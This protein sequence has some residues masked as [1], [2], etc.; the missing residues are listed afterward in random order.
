V[1]IQDGS[2]ILKGKGFGHGVGMC[3]WGARQLAQEGKSPE[4][5]IR[6]YFKGV[7]I[8]KYWP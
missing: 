6:F 2:L 5:I 3:Q 1:A 8:K 4:E 7:K